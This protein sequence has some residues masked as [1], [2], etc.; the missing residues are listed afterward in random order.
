MMYLLSAE[1]PLKFVVI[2]FLLHKISLLHYR[3]VSNNAFSS[4]YV[5][6]RSCD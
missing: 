2:M 4:F 6:G 5:T 3:Y 1:I